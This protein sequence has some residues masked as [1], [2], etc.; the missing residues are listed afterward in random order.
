MKQMKVIHK[1]RN[2]MIQEFQHSVQFQLIEVMK[3]VESI[4]DQQN[5]QENRLV[6][7]IV[8]DQLQVIYDYTSFQK[9]LNHR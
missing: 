9:M 3:N 4:D 2:R 6:L 8:H 7:Q 1:M 5:Q